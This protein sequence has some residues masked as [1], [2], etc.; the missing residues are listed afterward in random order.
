MFYVL[1]YHG[2][3]MPPRNLKNSKNVFRGEAP[4]EPKVDSLG[5]E[6][7]FVSSGIFVLVPQKDICKFSDSS[8]ARKVLSLSVHSAF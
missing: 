7:G 2:L 8:V 4:R 1:L 6:C 5:D 3:H